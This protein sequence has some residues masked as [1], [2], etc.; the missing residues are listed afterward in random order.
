MLDASRSDVQACVEPREPGTRDIVS[1]SRHDVVAGYFFSM[2]P[3]MGFEPIPCIGL[4]P[5]SCA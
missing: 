1:R 5:M 3:L 2:P 4:E